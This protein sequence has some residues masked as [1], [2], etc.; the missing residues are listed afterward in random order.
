MGGTRRRVACSRGDGAPSAW[1]VDV[2]RRSVGGE[3][4]RRSAWTG[5]RGTDAVIVENL[6]DIG[7]LQ[8]WEFV[9]GGRHAHGPGSDGRHGEDRWRRR[10]AVRPGGY[11]LAGMGAWPM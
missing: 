3:P 10:A 5:E 1:L 8:H 6:G 9:S 7:F 2:K 11:G 4:K